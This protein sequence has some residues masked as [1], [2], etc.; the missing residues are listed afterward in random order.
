MPSQTKPA[1]GGVTPTTKVDAPERVPLDKDGKPLPK[2]KFQ[3]VVLPNRGPGRGDH[4]A[5]NAKSPG[6]AAGHVRFTVACEPATVAPGGQGTLVV[7]MALAGNAVMLDPPPAEFLFERAQ[8]G[9]MVVGEPRFRPA[10]TSGLAPALKGLPV[11]DDL[12]VLEVPFT[13]DAGAA[14]G[15]HPLDLAIRYE[16]LDGQKGGE[17]GRFTDPIAGTVTVSPATVA[18]NASAPAVGAAAKPHGLDA[19]GDAGDA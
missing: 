1:A 2:P 11:Y 8:G 3:P 16:L 19:G 12:A 7:Y 17:I 18:P 10:Q 5:E 4:P 9:L 15:S 14:V 13:V 6:A